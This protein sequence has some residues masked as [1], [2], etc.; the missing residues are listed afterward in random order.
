MPQ[1]PADIYEY[2][3]TRFV[4]H[5]MRTLKWSRINTSGRLIQAYLI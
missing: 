5:S 3:K 1:M 4:L 2:S